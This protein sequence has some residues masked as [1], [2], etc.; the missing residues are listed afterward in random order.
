MKK[1]ANLLISTLLC[2]LLPFGSF[3]PCFAAESNES[4]ILFVTNEECYNENKTDL[5]VDGR[6]TASVDSDYITYAYIDGIDLNSILKYNAV[7]LPFGNSRTAQLAGFAFENG[8]L[9]YLYGELTIEDYKRTLGLNDFSLRDDI[10]YIGKGK[11]EKTVTY[12]DKAFECSE[13][14]NIISYGNSA[15][16]CKFNSTPDLSNYYKAVSEDF[17][18]NNASTGINST[19]VLTSKFNMVTYWGTN[20]RYSVHFNYTLYRETAE[21]DNQ[22]DYLAIKTTAWVIPGTATE[23]EE[24]DTKYILPYASDHL[25]ETAPASQKNIGTLNVSLSFGDG[26]VKGTIGYSI[27]LSDSCPT[28]KRTQDLANGTVEWALTKRAIFAKNI[29]DATLVPVAS[30]A[31]TGKMAAIDLYYGGKVSFGTNNQYISDSG[32]TRVPIRFSYTD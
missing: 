28:I 21:V 9:V 23:V 32:Y 25:M 27:D 26:T 17:C 3:M 30:W 4:K 11:T 8:L 19:T 10:Y 20:N 1:L 29:D 16:L 6:D 13:V 22:Y 18:G 15:L 5:N 14:Y 31:S 12:F 7:A 24:I 2:L